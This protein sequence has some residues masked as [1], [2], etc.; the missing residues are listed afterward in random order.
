MASRLAPRHKPHEVC[1][2]RGGRG[3]VIFLVDVPPCLD[4][5]AIAHISQHNPSLLL[6]TLCQCGVQVV[7]WPPIL[8]SSL[9]YLIVVAAARGGAR[10]YTPGS[11]KGGVEALKR[12]S[13]LPTSSDLGAPLKARDRLQAASRRAPGPLNA[14]DACCG[15]GSTRPNGLVPDPGPTSYQTNPRFTWANRSTYLSQHCP[16]GPDLSFTHVFL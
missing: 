6:H 4:P 1:Q 16:N 10:T 7:G 2:C 14:Q 12:A 5:I 13:G 15:G 8:L 3:R 11:P 9:N